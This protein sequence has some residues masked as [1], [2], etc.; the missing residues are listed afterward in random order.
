M[1]NLD[2]YCCDCGTSFDNRLEHECNF[3]CARC[4][5][6]NSSNIDFNDLDDDSLWCDDCVSQY[7]EQCPGC[8]TIYSI[9]RV[10]SRL[11]TVANG[12]DY[13]DRCVE[14]HCHRCRYCDAWVSDSDDCECEHDND[15]DSDDNCDCGEVDIHNYSCKSILV[16]HGE[17]KHGLFMG[18]ELETQIRSRLSNA[19]R[20][21]ARYAS[22]VLRSTELGQ[23]KYDSSI[24][25]DDFEGFEIVTQPHTYEEYRDN[26]QTLW[27]MIDVLRVDHKARSWDTTTCGLHIHISRDG[28][29][30]GLHQH[31]F[32]AFI[33]R[34][35][36][37]MM[38]FAGR[39]TSWAKFDDIYIWDEYSRPQFSVEEKV[40]RGGRTAVNTGNG[41]TLELRFFRGTMNP[42][43]VLAALAL[44]HAAVEFTRDMTGDHNKPEG[45]EWENFYAYVEENREKYPT[46]YERMPSIQSFDLNN[47]PTIEA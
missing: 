22:G 4:G 39:K 31:R 21:A 17:D 28:F 32:I 41:D 5:H 7:A 44:A 42:A 19:H 9:L 13:C 10:G 45:F 16:F 47:I 37:Y 12:N 27:D 35:V 30:D 34:N 3:T 18:F 29:K 20:R 46:L 33:Y 14:D 15:D 40:R 24:A 8:E 6:Q 43:G 11:I 1:P 36:E 38:K 25:D 26:S 23:L 2:G